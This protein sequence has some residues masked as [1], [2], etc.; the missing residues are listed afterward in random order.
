MN[1]I[2]IIL[3]LLIANQSNTEETAYMHQD[4]IIGLWDTYID[5]VD[6]KKIQEMFSYF[7]LPATLHFDQSDPVVI[8]SEEN[9]KEIFNVWKDSPQANF[10]HT[11]REGI[12][13]NEI[14]EDFSCVAD[15]VYKRLDKENNIISRT[16]SLYH[17]IY[18]DEKWKIYMITN[19]ETDQDKQ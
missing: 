15:V 6:N 14:I 3:S 18:K 5:A 13:V 8:E 7:Y 1:K 11:E 16:R 12:T 19:V 10:H 9:F 4:V 2:L 17:Y